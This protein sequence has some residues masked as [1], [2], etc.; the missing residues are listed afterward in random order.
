MNLYRTSWISLT[1]VAVLILVGNVSGAA[2]YPLSTEELNRKKADLQLEQKLL[3]QTEDRLQ[4]ELKEKK[5]KQARVEAILLKAKYTLP[6]LS[7]TGTS[8][9][10]AEQFIKDKEQ[11]LKEIA[12]EI[13]LLQDKVKKAQDRSR[14]TENQIKEID[15]TLLARVKGRFRYQVK[16]DAGYTATRYFPREKY[17]DAARYRDRLN[18]HKQ[19]FQSPTWSEYSEV[20]LPE[21]NGVNG[22]KV[23]CYVRKP[24]L[25]KS[26]DSEAEAEQRRKE[27]ET[28]G[29]KARLEKV[30]R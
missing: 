10:Q 21:E 17:T 13:T 29:F 12:K 14:D 19:N 23:R 15:N 22:W 18:S 6:K 2:N 27:L 28:W 30:P 3:K 8:L 7:S 26:F 25:D 9:N 24:Y 16:I 5:Q 1:T 20:H 4:D 11:E